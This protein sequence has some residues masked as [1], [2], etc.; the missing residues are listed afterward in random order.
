MEN[1]DW[2]NLFPSAMIKVLEVSSYDHLLLYLMLNRQ[3]YV[4]KVKRFPFEN[5]WIKEDKCRNIVLDC[6]N[7]MDVPNIVDKMLWVCLKLEE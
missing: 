2:L 3:V 7:R 1:V 4:P 6:W 5:M